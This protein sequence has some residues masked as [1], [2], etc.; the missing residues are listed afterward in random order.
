MFELLDLISIKTL[1]VNNVFTFAVDSN[2]ILRACAI[3]LLVIPMT[4]T[5]VSARPLLALFGDNYNYIDN[6]HISST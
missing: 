5:A 1:S 6:H 2:I 4:C 3:E